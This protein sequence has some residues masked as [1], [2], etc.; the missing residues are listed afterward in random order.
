MQPVWALRSRQL[1]TSLRYWLAIVGYDRSDHSLSHKIYLGYAAIFFAGW[2]FAVLSLLGGGTLSGLKALQPLLQYE[3]RP[4]PLFIIAAFWMLVL[5]LAWALFRAWGAARRSPLVFN[6][7]DAHLVCQTPVSRRAV[8]FAWLVG[9]WAVQALFLGAAGVVL[10]FAVIEG[11]L[12]QVSITDIPLYAAVGVRALVEIGLLVGG[13]LGLVW[14]LGC[15]RLRPVGQGKP[16]GRLDLFPPGLAVFLGLALF[17]SGDIGSF[18]QLLSPLSFPIQQAFAPLAGGSA[19]AWLTLAGGLAGAAAWLLVGMAA[20]WFASPAINLSQAAQETAFAASLQA[21][22]ATGNTRAYRELQLVQRL[23]VQPGRASWLA[24]RQPGPGWPALLWKH[25]LQLERRGAGSFFSGWVWVLLAGLGAALAPDWGSRGWA[26]LVWSTL[27]CQR[28]AEFTRA[29][30]AQWALL[31][32]LPLSA[33]QVL[34]VEAALPAALASALGG[35]ALL[36][37]RMAS[38]S[39]LPA[40]AFLFL[41]P[42]AL[43]LALAGAVDVLRPAHTQTLLAGQAPSA[44]GV[45]LAIAAVLLAALILGSAWL[46]ERGA[47]LPLVVL[48]GLLLILGG[49]WVLLEFGTDM[50]RNIE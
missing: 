50:L 44:G 7:D 25:A 34:L 13:L 23:G 28:A 48:S 2:G 12:A 4:A 45:S 21:A 39:G 15:L 27:V 10:A 3:S 1:A 32:G 8:A 11:S 46:L 17:L 14:A 33:R 24:G 18:F 43:A 16:A 38:G 35:L 5:L 30:L 20:L 9:D 36:T 37:G 26:L 6:E 49:A 47:P 29:D 31:R 41:P 22:A 42:L 19:S 40:Y